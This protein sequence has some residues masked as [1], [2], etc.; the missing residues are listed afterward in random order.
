M[1]GKPDKEDHLNVKCPTGRC[2]PPSGGRSAFY[3]DSRTSEIRQWGCPHWHTAWRFMPATSIILLFALHAS[4]VSFEVSGLWALPHPTVTFVTPLPV[5]IQIEQANGELKTLKIMAGALG[6]HVEL[7]RYRLGRNA[8]I[9]ATSKGTEIPFPGET[10]LI[11]PDGA[12]TIKH[13]SEAPLVLRLSKDS[14]QCAGNEVR[15]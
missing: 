13:G 12:L 5:S 1:Q 9:R 8:K 15:Q 14:V 11:G 2:V 10:W 7:D 3:I 4:L 6:S